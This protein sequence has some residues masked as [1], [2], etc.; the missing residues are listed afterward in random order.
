MDERIVKDTELNKRQEEWLRKKP[1]DVTPKQKFFYERIVTPFLRSFFHFLRHLPFYRILYYREI[2]GK[3]TYSLSRS[4]HDNSQRLYGR[5]IRDLATDQGGRKRGI[6]AYSNHI[7]ELD[8]AI[9]P[10]I[11]D[12]LDLGFCYKVTKIEYF[13]RRLPAWIMWA[14]G[15]RPIVRSTGQGFRNTMRLAQDKETLLMYP[16]GTRA[17]KHEKKIPFHEGAA[18]L[19]A[20]YDMVLAP[21]FINRVKG[22]IFSYYEVYCGPPVISSNLFPHI[23]DKDKRKAAITRFM[24]SEISVP[25]KKGEGK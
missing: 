13:K 19:A 9:E 10:Y 12:Q 5:E 16:Q 18:D 25:V 17:K 1:K 6:M 3:M 7:T 11:I 24:A 4:R 15:C 2:N 20:K 23:S 8:T 14:V 21:F 22:F